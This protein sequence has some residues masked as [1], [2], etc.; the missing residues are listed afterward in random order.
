MWYSC[1][2]P[3]SAVHR[4]SLIYIFFP[5]YPASEIRQCDARANS[6]PICWAGRRR[7]FDDAQLNAAANFRSFR[8]NIC[9]LYNYFVYRTAVHYATLSRY[10]PRF[11]C[12]GRLVRAHRS[13]PQSC[14]RS[15][16]RNH[17]R[18]GRSLRST[19][20]NLYS[21][22]DF[23][24]I[25]IRPHV[26]AQG[27][28]RRRAGLP[29]PRQGVYPMAPC[30]SGATHRGGVARPFLAPPHLAATHRAAR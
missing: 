28:G 25:L 5:R 23:T 6:A 17:M 13:S 21:Q 18:R 20:K 16:W 3:I 10:R 27:G 1:T 7:S 26:P 29:R 8:K 30:S 11:R 22:I 9:L 15:A 14:A 24:E 4:R 12:S 2:R 19:L